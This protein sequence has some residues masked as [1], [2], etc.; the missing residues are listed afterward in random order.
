MSKYKV[1]I[2]GI[3]TNALKVL[4]NDEMLKK[5]RDYQNGNEL[6]KEDIVN[7]NLK[8]WVFIYFT[9]FPFH[10]KKRHHLSISSL[11]NKK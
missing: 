4:K 6:A 3:N 8:N 11:I 9:S 5:F 1:D 10:T 7:G 2:T